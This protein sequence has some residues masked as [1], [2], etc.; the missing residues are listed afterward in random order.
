MPYD[1]SPHANKDLAQVQGTQQAKAANIIQQQAAL[2]RART[3]AAEQPAQLQTAYDK[4]RTGGLES[5]RQ[6]AQAGLA[7]TR[8][9]N[10]SNIAQVR[11][12]ALSR[13]GA[14]AGFQ[15]DLARQWEPM[16]SGAKLQA[17]TTESEILGKERQLLDAAQASKA[18]ANQG[19]AKVDEF[20]ASTGSVY[21]TQADRDR[22]AK[23]AATQLLEGE[24]DPTVRQAI[25]DQIQRYQSGDLK[26]EA[27]GLDLPW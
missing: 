8:G 9:R 25:M 20:F 16:I 27:G 14:E 19:R 11:Q 10:P 5:I 21:N 6:Q 13:G 7:L 24:D 3:A 12:T 22:A 2:E 18:R 17:A 26:G 4:A 1:I 15:S 23:D